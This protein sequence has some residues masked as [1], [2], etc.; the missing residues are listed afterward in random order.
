MIM[1][2]MKK[3]LLC[4][5]LI[6]IFCWS[7]VSGLTALAIYPSAGGRIGEGDGTNRSSTVTGISLFSGI[8]G[9]ILYDLVTSF[10]KWK[11]EKKEPVSFKKVAKPVFS[12]PSDNPIGNPEDKPSSTPGEAPNSE[13]GTGTGTGEEGGSESGED[14]GDDPRD[15]FE[16]EVYGEEIEGC[17]GP[18]K[19]RSRIMADWRVGITKPKA[20]SGDGK[21]ELSGIHVPDGINNAIVSELA[22]WVNNHGM[23][24]QPEKRE[25]CE[26]KGKPQKPFTIWEDP[27]YLGEGEPDWEVEY[28]IEPSCYCVQQPPYDQPIQT[29]K[30][31]DSKTPEGVLTFW[32]PSEEVVRK[33]DFGREGY[34]TLT[35][36]PFEFGDD[37]VRGEEEHGGMGG[38]TIQVIRQWKIKFKL[39]L[40]YHEYVYAGKCETV[41]KK[42]K[43]GNERPKNLK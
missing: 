26:G 2:Q 14:E 29:F 33:R 38:P 30:Y 20:I 24:N 34:E 43:T 3:W 36:R 32:A 28:K 18:C 15:A 37:A 42:E 6:T 12:K 7:N 17:N 22:Q 16:P 10:I 27:L 23:G 25:G 31:I 5:L 21:K 1:V 4:G 19:I 40:F 41:E 11:K 39:M 9:L 35:G 8:S 13:P